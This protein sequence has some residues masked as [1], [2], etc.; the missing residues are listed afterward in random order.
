MEGRG[1][2]ITLFDVIRGEADGSRGDDHI[3]VHTKQDLDPSNGEYSSL[4]DGGGG[5]DTVEV[6]GDGRAAF[7]RTETIVKHDGI[8][9]TECSVGPCGRRRGSHESFWSDNPV[10]CE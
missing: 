6:Y 9:C 5:D 7:F 3:T 8:S 10:I 4:V 1:T 2:T